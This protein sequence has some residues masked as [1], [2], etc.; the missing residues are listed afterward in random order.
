MFVQ[1]VMLLAEEEGLATCPQQALAEYP[2]VVKRELGLTE[3]LLFVCAMALGYENKR[4]PVNQY[5]TPRVEL[6]EFV[7]FYS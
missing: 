4:A 7:R 3:G 2:D 1:S 6:E 5:R